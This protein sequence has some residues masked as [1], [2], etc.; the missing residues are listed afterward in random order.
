M[1]ALR[2]SLLDEAGTR[3]G[4]DIACRSLGPSLFGTLGIRGLR[5]SV[6]GGGASASAGGDTG[7]D[8][9]LLFTAARLRAAPAPGA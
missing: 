5:V 9:G 1:T 3:L 7:A 4:L 2:D 8:G 6:R